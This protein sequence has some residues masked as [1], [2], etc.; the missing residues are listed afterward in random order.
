MSSSPLKVV[1]TD[2]APGAI[3]PYSQAI[4]ANG[5]VFASGQIPVV[6]ETGNIVSDDVQEQTRQSIKNLQNVLEAANSS[7]ALLVKTTVFIKDM[8]DF[9]AINKVYAEFFGENRPARACVE[10][11]RLPKDVKIEIEGVAV[12]AEPKI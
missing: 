9:A 11:A 6:P 7:L 8:N 10:V 12:V 2:K 5:F 4:V 1:S 3:G